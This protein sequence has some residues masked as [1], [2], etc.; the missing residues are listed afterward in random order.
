MTKPIQYAIVKGNRP[1]F[2]SS[3]I[4]T[5]ARIEYEDEDKRDL[6]SS[7]KDVVGKLKE[8]E[9]VSTHPRMIQHF[10]FFDAKD[11]AKRFAK[12]LIDNDTDHYLSITV[13]ECVDDIW[14]VV[15]Y[16]WCPATIDALIEHCTPIRKMVDEYGGEHDGWETPIMKK[17]LIEAA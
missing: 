5:I 12:E 1:E 2:T 6:E 13:A 7:L 15:F 16:V 17:R 4:F 11:K 3:E 9:D 14:Q 8:M 10:A